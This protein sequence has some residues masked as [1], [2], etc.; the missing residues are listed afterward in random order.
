[1]LQK[2]SIDELIPLF[3]EEAK[4]IKSKNFKAMKMKVGLG[5]KEDLK[6]VH[7]VRDSVGKDFKLMVDANHTYNL[8][9]ALYVGKGLDELDIYWFEEPVSPE[10]Y[11]G[12]RELKQKISTSI[13][14]GEAEFTKYGWNKLI[15]SLIHI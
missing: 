2:K 14:G 3:Q 9:D 6:L 1:M 4:Q 11:E 15:L 8:K 10:D 13:A 12:Y 5:P 7:A